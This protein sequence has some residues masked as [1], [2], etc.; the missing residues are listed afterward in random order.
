MS[1]GPHESQPGYS[2]AQLLKDGCGECAAR[3]ASPWLAIQHM[4]TR[5]FERAWQRAVAFERG[6]LN[7][8][9]ETEIPVLRIMWAVALQFE[10]KGFSLTHAPGPWDIAAA[11]MP[12]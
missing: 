4:D 9:C 10:R 8:V 7:D 11:V 12:L 2:P 5:T 3:S 1:H 6:Q